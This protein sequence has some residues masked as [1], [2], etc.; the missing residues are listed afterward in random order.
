MALPDNK[1]IDYNNSYDNDTANLEEQG[2]SCLMNIQSKW[3]K[4]SQRKTQEKLHSLG[5]KKEPQWREEK[6][7]D[8]SDT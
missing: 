1:V 5:L 7:Q 6:I 2:S 3:A 4:K 8:L